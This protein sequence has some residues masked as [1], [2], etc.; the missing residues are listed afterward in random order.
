MTDLGPRVAVAVVGVPA[1]LGLLYAGGWILGLPL[2]VFAAL[3]AGEVYRFGE[4]R[5]LHP[6][7]WLGMPA[8]AALVGVAVARTDYPEVAPWLL[9]IL[10]ALLVSALTAAL[11]THGPKRAPL[12][13]VAVTLFGTAYAGLPLTCVLLLHALPS[14]MGWGAVEPTRWVGAMVVALPLAATWIG[15]AAAYFA[16]SAWGRAKLF[17]SIS[18]KKSWVGAWAGIL[19]A[20]AGA[21]AW[22]TV[23]GSWLPGLPLD[24]VTTWALVG[25]G[26]GVAAILGD[27]AESLLKREAG[28]KD[29]GKLLPGHG[30]VLDRLDAL[31]YT[32]PVAYIVLRLAEMLA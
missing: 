17:P 1:V 19:G 27:L 25:A 3:G 30:G 12:P 22:Y 32:I 26:L 4:T 5:G 31:A 13:S 28:M 16:G 20:A 7:T 9:A 24:G 8:T 11:W 21:V 23:V 2:A 6:S 18:P 29:S 14:R 15:D 10:A